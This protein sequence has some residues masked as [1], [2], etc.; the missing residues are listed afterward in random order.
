[1]LLVSK[2]RSQNSD[3]KFCTY[4]F[5]FASALLIVISLL[6]LYQIRRLINKHKVA[7]G[8]HCWRTDVFVTIGIKAVNQFYAAHA[9]KQH[10]QFNGDTRENWESGESIEPTQTTDWN[11]TIDD[12][13]L[14]VSDLRRDLWSNEKRPKDEDEKEI[15]STSTP[16]PSKYE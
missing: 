4:L 12:G 13:G 6:N 14:Q 2:I 5:I 7:I 10:T 11:K 8:N 15:G 3:T 9:E 1:M 16:T